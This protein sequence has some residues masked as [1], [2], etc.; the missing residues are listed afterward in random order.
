MSRW[1]DEH[2]KCRVLHPFDSV[3]QQDHKSRVILCS[4]LSEDKFCADR[5]P[6]A[7]HS[8]LH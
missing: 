3:H 8:T 6:A 1:K 4:R 5:Y 7:P 2:G